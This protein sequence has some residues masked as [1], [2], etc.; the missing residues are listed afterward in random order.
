MSC[1]QFR[2]AFGIVITPV[3]S[4]QPYALEGKL[5]SSREKISFVETLLFPMFKTPVLKHFSQNF[6]FLS[7]FTLFQGRSR[8][9]TQ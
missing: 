9:L 1:H 5:V 3:I 2:D 7:L 8:S 4:K 6:D